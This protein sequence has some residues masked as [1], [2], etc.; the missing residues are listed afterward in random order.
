MT[1]L[2]WHSMCCIVPVP[3]D[4]MSVTKVLVKYRWQGSAVRHQHSL[5][6][7]IQGFNATTLYHLMATA[8]LSCNPA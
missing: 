8:G 3:Q 2:D 5:F 4:C 1:R 7:A 6:Q